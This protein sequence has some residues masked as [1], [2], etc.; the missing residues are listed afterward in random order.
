MN[1]L[2][3]QITASFFP[4]TSDYNTFRLHWSNLVNS[5]RKH[6]LKA[7]HH[8]AY[9]VFCGK[10]WRKAFTFPTNLNKINNGY[11]PELYR[12]L[13][14]FFSIYQEHYVLDPFEGFVSNE[15]LVRAR[16]YLSHV[17]V[18]SPKVDAR[19]AYACDAYSTPMQETTEK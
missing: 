4:S 13:Q 8:L 9:L 11:T 2:S 7:V 17:R 18:Y 16:S 10:D 5:E 14:Q 3:R 6:E 19:G 15:A 1:M 12:A